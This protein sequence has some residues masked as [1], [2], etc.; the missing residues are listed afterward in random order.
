MNATTDTVREY[1]P[2]PVR[3]TAF[4]FGRHHGT[5]S[6]RWKVREDDAF[7]VTATKRGGH[8]E[9]VVVERD[10]GLRATCGD[11]GTSFKVAVED[12]TLGGVDLRN[13]RC[14]GCGR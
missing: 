7:N 4:A 11:C 13:I 9:R 10:G 1:A 8:E 14:L 12:V 6:V 2:D 5:K 3:R